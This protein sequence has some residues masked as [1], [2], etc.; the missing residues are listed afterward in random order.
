MYPIIEVP[1]DAPELTEQVGTKLKFWFD[2]SRQLFK[3][4]RSR[5]GEDW[6]EKI[7]C[8]ICGLL[9]LP[10]A[11]YDLASW[12][13]RRGVVSQNF[14]SE[15]CALVHGN[16]LLGKVVGPVYPITKLYKVRQHTLKVVL[17]LMNALEPPIGFRAFPGVETALDVFI[18][19]LLLDA[20][21]GN[22][23]RHHQN[24]GLVF[25]PVGELHLAPTFDHASC[26]GR[27]ESDDEKRQRLGTKDQARTVSTYVVKCRSAFY[28]SPASEEPLSTLEVFRTAAR[29]NPNGALSWLKR[30][31]DIALTDTKRICQQ[32][33][34]A[35]MSDVSVEFAQR[36]LELNRL[37]LLDLVKEV[38]A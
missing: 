20:W 31:Q 3:E 11:S 10:H 2:G 28:H 4:V 32:I 33:P 17:R 9:E 29:A 30:L 18:G 21:I 25:T 34:S 5:T 26:L 6:A 24:W 16:Q 19:Y 7:A 38:M 1:D 35:R 13:G 23:D 27:I 36:I 37:R 12:K 8:E 14:L 22:N 15:G